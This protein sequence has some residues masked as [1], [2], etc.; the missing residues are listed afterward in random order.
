MITTT[1]LILWRSLTVRLNGAEYP[2]GFSPADGSAARSMEFP[3]AENV[4]ATEKVD[5]ALS[6]PAAIVAQRSDLSS[7]NRI[8][9]RGRPGLTAAWSISR[10]PGAGS[11]SDE[12]TVTRADAEDPAADAHAAPPADSTAPPT[13]SASTFRPELTG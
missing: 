2:A 9:W 3:G 13:S 5:L 12:E 7:C 6:R 11:A 8:R 1:C 10:S 4:R